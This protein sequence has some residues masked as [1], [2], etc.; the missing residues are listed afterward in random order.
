MFGAVV[1][2]VRNVAIVFALA[3]IVFV[4]PGGSSGAD[5]VQAVLSLAITA[6]I[7]LIGARLY[8]EYRVEIFSLD[9]HWRYVLYGSFAALIWCFAGTSKLWATGGGLLIWLVVAVAAVY[10]LIRVWRAYR[11]Y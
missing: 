6:T 8:R 11:A 4:V 9:D 1:K 3:A 7:A 2:N 10:G 5:L